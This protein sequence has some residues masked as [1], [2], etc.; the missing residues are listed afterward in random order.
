MGNRLLPYDE[1]FRIFITTKIKNA[2]YPIEL[3]TRTTVVDFTVRQ[4]GLEERLL[5]ILIEIENPGLEVL[6]DN[7]VGSIERDQKSL[8]EIQDELLELLDESECS[9]LE[10]EQLH[11][12]LKS[13]KATSYTIGEQLQ[14]SLASQA[15]ISVA[16][17]VRL[18]QLINCC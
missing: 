12:T 1:N 7:T 10:N 3:L 5:K 11:R 4:E 2:P 8:A 16:R 13:S 9:L 18:N 14:S 15:E 17:E 6:R